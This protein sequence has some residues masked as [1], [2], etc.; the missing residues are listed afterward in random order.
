[1]PE[2]SAPHFRLQLATHLGALHLNVDL[3]LT[4]PWTV[5]FGPSGSGK[6]TILRAAC[7]LL[8]HAKIQSSIATNGGREE[9]DGHHHLPPHQRRLGYAPQGAVLF[10]HLTARENIAF[11]AAAHHDQAAIPRLTTTAIKLF[12]L[13]SLAARMPRDL[14]GGERQRVNLARAFAVPAP[15]MFLLDEPFTGVDRALRDALLPRMQRHAAQLGI[16][17]LSVTHDVEEALMLGAEVIRLHDGAIVD[18][19][20]ASQVLAGERARILQILQP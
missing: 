5:I 19:G 18:Q 14:S 3:A 10:P 16:P 7:G 20:P 4:A 8:P 12:D 13:E 11:P 1:M 2:P 9:L 6:S 15:R 17:V